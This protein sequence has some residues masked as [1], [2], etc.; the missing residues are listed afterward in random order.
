MVAVLMRRTVLSVW[1]TQNLGDKENYG[2]GR[3]GTKAGREEG[4]EG[5]NS[6]R[7]EN[8]DDML[9]CEHIE[10]ANSFRSTTAYFPIAQCE[11]TT[12]HMHTTINP[13]LAGSA[14]E[15]TIP[16]RGPP[17]RGR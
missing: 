10:R 16:L 5:V 7:R 13:H 8:D 6:G 17:K 14:V 11:H 2:K 1:E 4:S 15:A 9:R 3:A 12:Q